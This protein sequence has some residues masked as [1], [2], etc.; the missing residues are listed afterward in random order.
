MDS[1]YISTEEIYSTYESPVYIY[2]DDFEKGLEKVS[3]AKRSCKMNQM[4]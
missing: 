3:V 1:T 2:V 4:Y